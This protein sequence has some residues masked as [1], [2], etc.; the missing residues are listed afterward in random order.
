MNLKPDTWR[1]T[2]L[3]Q[4]RRF[5]GWFFVGVT[6]TG[7]YCRPVCPVRTPKRQTT[8]FSNVAATEKA[9]FRRCLRCRQSWPPETDY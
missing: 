2:L 3:S 4:D 7:I 6:L 5:D 9:G 8:I 1:Q